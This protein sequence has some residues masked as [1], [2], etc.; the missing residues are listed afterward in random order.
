MRGIYRKERQEGGWAG[1]PPTVP[2][3]IPL[4]SNLRTGLEVTTLTRPTQ[5]ITR[6][7]PRLDLCNDEIADRGILG[8]HK[9]FASELED[10]L[11]I[12]HP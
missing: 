8:S 5:A 6:S 11:T 10:Y 12:R 3:E 1:C 4:P 9:S 7:L 2:I